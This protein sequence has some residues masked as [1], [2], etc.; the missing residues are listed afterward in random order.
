MQLHD[1]RLSKVVFGDK[2][3]NYKILDWRKLCAAKQFNNLGKFSLWCCASDEPANN[4]ANEVTRG[5]SALK[6]HHR[7][8]RQCNDVSMQKNFHSAYELY[9][10][11]AMNF[12]HFPPHSH[13]FTPHCSRS[14]ALIFFYLNALHKFMTWNNPL[15]SRSN[16]MQANVRA[17]SRRVFSIHIA[18]Q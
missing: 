12:N 8:S 16:R 2:K 11:G 3:F 9:I 18:R 6:T 5:T 1:R 10:N 14:L 17:E 7:H 15:C 13:A 4:N